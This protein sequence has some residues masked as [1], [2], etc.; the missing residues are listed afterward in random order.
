MKRRNF[1]KYVG[2][3]SIAATTVV[4]ALLSSPNER[5][6]REQLIHRDYQSNNPGTEYFFLGNGQ[7]IAAVQKTSRAES[8]THCGLLLMASERFGRKMSTFLFHPERGLENSRLMVGVDDR[9]FVP[10]PGE[11]IIG[12]A[13]PEEIPTVI[14]DWH[15]GVCRIRESLSCPSNEPAVV[16]ELSVTNEGDTPVDVQAT[17]VLHP[18]L[19]LFDEYEVDR[20]DMIL[21]AKGYHQV[22]L[23]SDAECTV[24]DR[25][26]RF[27]FG[28]L[29]PGGQRSATAYLTVDYTPDRFR[30]KSIV[31]I[32][33]ETSEYW[34][35]TATFRSSNEKLNHLFQVSKTGARA[36]I[37]RSGKMDGGVWQYNLEWVRDQSMM[38]VASCM[39]GLTDVAETI[40]RRM[41][42]FS[43]DEEGGTVESSRFRPPETMELDQNGTLLYTIWSHWVWTGDDSIIRTYW[44]KIRKVADYVLQPVFRDPEIG[45]VKNSREYWERDSWFGVKDGYEITY[46]FWNI[47]GLDKAV[48]MAEYLNKQTE[49]RRWREASD[50]MNRSFL[51]H[52]TLSL[53][54]D[55]RF[56][57]RRLPDGS[58]QRT[59]EPPNRATMPPGMPLNV[60]KVSYCDPDSSSALPIAWGLVDAKSDLSLNTLHALEHLWNQRWDYGGYA[61]YDVTSEPD[62]PGPW[63]FATMFIARAYH[64]AGDYDKVWRSLDWLLSVQGANSGSWYEFYGDRPTPPLPPVG[65]VVWT[66]GEIS[67]YF[68]HH[69]LGIRPDRESVTIRPRLLPGVDS[70]SG[71]VIIHGHNVAYDFKR[72]EQ[73]E[74]AV[75]D[76]VRHSLTDGAL[77]IPI[78]DKNI[79]VTVYCS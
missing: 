52:P 49:A 61:R 29:A 72:T 35:K 9:S 73:Q 76:G 5:I 8:G 62:S 17:L 78:P 4:P 23:F 13:Y 68:V 56:I 41:L 33:R 60:E 38:A 6:S 11:A 46:Q 42:E 34:K 37:A 63:P 55:G 28:R 26:M 54:E 43:V 64:E 58:V 69:L 20:S 14:I 67:M 39:T 71:T 7:I 50:L 79:S 19:I 24:G 51:E 12:W 74:Y 75:V 15:A 48:I 59:F 45:L 65:I 47:L 57:K 21:T 66:W 30:S 1:I 70:V 25:H 40:I 16:R 22:R 31:T 44:E 53:V 32:R 18:N 36:A 2:A 27:S 77:R 10:L 3:G